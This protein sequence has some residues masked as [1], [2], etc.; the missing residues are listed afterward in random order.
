MPRFA[1]NLSMMYTEVPFMARFEAAAKDGF[2]AV[3]F[4]FPYAFDAHEIKA[5]LDAHGLQQVLFN[6]PPGDWESGERG[7]SSLVDRE[8]EFQAGIAKAIEYAKVLNCPRVHVMAGLINKETKND[9]DNEIT[10][11]RSQW[12]QYKK[13]LG[14]AAKQFAA[15]NIMGLVEPINTRDVPGYLINR[16][17]DAHRIIAEVLLDAN[18]DARHLRVQMDLYHVQIVE[19][20]VAMKIRQ[21]I[22]G[23]GHI[24]IAGVP[25]RHEPSVGELNYPYLFSLLDE[26]GYNGWIGCEYRPK[27]NTSDGLQWFKDAA[28]L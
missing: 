1:A 3:E 18:V 21:F 27:G 4:L 2:K 23:V 15:A 26:L 6:A 16:Q 13:S 14:F 20:D 22:D 8:E 24:Q 7:L 19:G 10:L 28:A 11:I 17:A 25:E 5:Q 12:A 9:T